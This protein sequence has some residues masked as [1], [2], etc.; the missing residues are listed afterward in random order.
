MLKDKRGIKIYE[1]VPQI[2]GVV[3]FSKGDVLISNIR[4]YLKKIWLADRAG[5]CSPDVLVFR[6]RDENILLA[7]YL[8]EVLREDEFFAFAMSTVT[9][10]KMPRGDKDKIK[11][12]NFPLPP[13][14]VQKKIVE[15]FAALDA[16]I[17]SAQEMIT[18]LDADIKAKFNELFGIYSTVKNYSFVT[19]CK[20]DT[21]SGVKFQTSEYQTTGD[22][23]IIDQGANDIAGYMNTKN[24]P[25]PY[26]DL[27]CVIFGDHT[28]IFKFERK[29][30]YLGAD[31]TKIIVPVNR[32]ELDATFLFYMLKIEYRPIGGYARHFK[33][34]KSLKLYLPPLELQKKFAA[35][36]EN[37]EA[38]KSSARAN[39]EK[40]ILEREELVTKYFR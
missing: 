15:E 21:A 24:N 36:V 33:N 4:P 40:L 28:E 27:P 17:L 23:P 18:G 32:D 14:D 22:I 13:I 31:G 19:L 1:G 29:R 20:D 3:K 9:G 10:I 11:S 5:G 34:L 30:F 25:S 16:K 2:S 37:C 7:E 35:Y 12:Y 26:E 38:L 6:S 8:F 39:R